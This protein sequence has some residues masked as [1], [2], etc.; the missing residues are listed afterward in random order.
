[1]GALDCR[2]CGKEKPEHIFYCAD[3]YKCEDCGS[4]KGLIIRTKELTC[5]SCHDKRAADRVAEFSG[6]TNDTSE[7]TCPWCG[8]RKSD[9]W[10]ASDE[11]EHT[12]GYCGHDYEHNREIVVTY[13]TA[14]VD[15]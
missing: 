5:D 2:T 10:E 15:R 9:S 7:I 6:D 14:K 12:C 4:K 8:H 13:N 3:C 1:M 11:G